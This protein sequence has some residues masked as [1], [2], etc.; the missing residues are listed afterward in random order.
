MKQRILSLCALLTFLWVTPAFSNAPGTACN[1]T[2]GVSLHPY[3]SWVTNI[4][5]NA[6]TVVPLIPT[7]ADPHYYQPLPA[8]M[9]RLA[10]LDVVVIN[11]IGHDEFVVPM[12]K[13]IDTE[14]LQIIDTSKGLPLIPSFGKRYTEGETN[15]SYNSHTYIAITGAIQQIQTIARTLGG[16]C[17]DQAPHFIKNAQAY[18]AR[19]RNM[20]HA[21]LM[22]IEALNA[23]KLRIATVHD[24]YS[25]LL[26]ELGLEV[27]A[28][29]QP[30]HGIKPSPRQL[31]DTIKRI[32]SANV[33][34]LF[35][36]ID[37]EKK[38]VDIIY[39]ETGC[40]L[41][42]LSHISYGE[43]TP[44][45]FEENMRENMNNIVRALREVNAELGVQ[46]LPQQILEENMSRQMEET[47]KKMQERI[48]E[49]LQKAIPAAQTQ[50]MQKSMSRQMEE[51]AQK[52][53]Q[54]MKDN[55]QKAL[56]T[57]QQIQERSENIQETLKERL[58]QEGSQEAEAQDSS[59]P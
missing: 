44:E 57:Q 18:S 9:E 16:I 48:Q 43:Y 1:L 51:T 42:Y 40:R 27:S 19:L 36:E 32:K 3:Y 38:Y 15:I 55:L 56:P 24:G 6:A 12:L 22:Q 4:V 28:V 20:L 21:T 30:R 35:G 50:Q 11:G 8:D 34:V 5:G 54:G 10:G 39:Q 52:M 58:K 47:A 26:Q 7:D 59:T 31:Q 37:Y 2:I 53:Q 23:E 33:N 46:A 41:Y 25:Y 29:V 45:H 17:P 13:A 14:H 49:N